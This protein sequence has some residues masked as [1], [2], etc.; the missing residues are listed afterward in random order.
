MKK[1]ILATLVALLFVFV[2]GG[3][4]EAATRQTLTTGDGIK[5]SWINP[6]TKP[7]SEYGTVSVKI[8]IINPTGP[9][10]ATVA[11]VDSAGSE[12]TSDVSS[13]VRARGKS[14][15]RFAIRGGELRG[16]K[17]PYTLSFEIMGDQDD[18]IEGRFTFEVP[19]TITC[20][21][22]GKASKKVTAYKPVCPAG[23]TK[24]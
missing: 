24:R 6:T 14:S 9:M 12:V 23:Y 4:A 20:A 19:T 10:F 16:T 5:F 7:T 8:D 2:Q 3:V 11:L 15:M 18:F 21:K 22:K 17:A 1:K 13:M